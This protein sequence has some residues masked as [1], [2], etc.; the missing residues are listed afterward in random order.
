MGYGSRALELL[1]EF[2]EG[3]I[4]NLNETNIENS[5]DKH[6]SENN[7]S[8]GEDINTEEVKPK[9]RLKPLLQRLSET[10]PSFV[11]YIGTA[12]GLTKE[13]FQFWR[14]AN[15]HPVYL[16]L[17]ENDITGEHSCI[18]IKPFADTDVKI[19]NNNLTSLNINDNE[20]V[21]KDSNTKWLAPYLYDFK[22]R[23]T[24]LFGFDFR[25]LPIS[26]SLSLLDPVLSSSTTNDN[27][28]NII[29]KASLKKVK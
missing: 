13:L 15:F 27:E 16:K 9:K 3:K 8:K 11:H 17:T 26:I 21:S 23:L 14:K 25:T 18:M 24:T 29:S 19:A 4:V 28:T 22:K 12:F 1:S 7:I 5:I 2:Y 10:K 6:V 20:E